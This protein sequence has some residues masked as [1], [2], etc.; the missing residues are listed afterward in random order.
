MCQSVLDVQ[1]YKQSLLLY[2]ITPLTTI[3]NV[4]VYGVFCQSYSKV[5]YVYHWHLLVFN[6]S[7]NYQC[8]KLGGQSYNKSALISLPTMDLYI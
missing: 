8:D 5:S 6:C 2:R 3:N 4:V 7:T 1:L